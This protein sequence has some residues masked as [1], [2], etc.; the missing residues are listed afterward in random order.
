[1][2][3]LEKAEEIRAK[4]RAEVVQIVCALETAHNMME[5]R[6][7]VNWAMAIQRAIDDAFEREEEEGPDFD[8]REG[9]RGINKEQ[10]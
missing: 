8:D 9:D 6:E 2:D 3:D 10:V 1:M 4:R 5:R 7:L